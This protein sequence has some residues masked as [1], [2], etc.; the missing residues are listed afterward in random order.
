[1]AQDQQY[2]TQ[3]ERVVKESKKA[4]EWAKETRADRRRLIKELQQAVPRDDDVNVATLDMIKS[5][6]IPDSGTDT[7]PDAP[8]TLDEAWKSSD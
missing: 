6:H 8:K 1:M 3:L 7:D 2:E 5:T 4:G